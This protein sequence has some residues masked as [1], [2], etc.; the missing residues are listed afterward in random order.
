MFLFC[1]AFTFHKICQYDFFF[2]FK[3]RKKAVCEE[4]HACPTSSFL[5]CFICH[6]YPPFTRKRIVSLYF[7]REV[8]TRLG[9]A[10][11]EV[12]GPPVFRIKV[13]HPVK[14]LAQ[15]HNKRT[16]WLVL[17]N[18]LLMPSVKQGSCEYHF[19]KSFGMTRQ[20]E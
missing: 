14:C 10:F 2:L 4:G 9:V 5:F 18:L 17:H 13:G 6:I 1:T 19:L 3:K 12:Y 15:E 8:R 7:G 11:F 20:G 16:C